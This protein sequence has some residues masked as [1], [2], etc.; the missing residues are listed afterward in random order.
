MKKIISLIGSR[1]KKSNTANLSNIFVENLCKKN[2]SEKFVYE[3]IQPEQWNLL[4][5]FSCNECFTKGFCANDRNDDMTSIK[6]KLLAADVIIWGSPVYAMHVSGDTKHLVD[7]LSMWTH[8]MPLIG[9]YGVTLSTASS[10]NGDKVISYLGDIMEYMGLQVIMQLNSFVRA[11]EPRIDRRDM[12]DELMSESI[13]KLSDALF[14]GVSLPVSERLR[15]YYSGQSKYYT[16]NKKMSK[17]YPETIPNGKQLV[18]E[19]QGYQDFKVID[20]LLKVL[21]A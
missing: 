3:L 21:R 5:C 14:K 10:N 1:S 13:I 17:L 9:K 6:E 18:W 19:K 11:G 15:S 8:T 16:Y 12:L 20:D 4:P 2:P 7:R